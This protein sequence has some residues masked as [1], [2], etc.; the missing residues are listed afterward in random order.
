MMCLFQVRGLTWLIRQLNGFP[1]KQGAGDVGAVRETISRLNEGYI[2]NVFPEGT[3]TLDGEI[4]QIQGGFSLIIRKVDV[5]VIPVAIH[6]S[7]R[8]WKPGTK[9]FKPGKI[10][11]RYGPPLH[12]KGLKPAQIVELTDRVLHQML[13]QLRAED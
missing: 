8:A 1:I 7:Y 4:S 12:V 2:L 6:G 9:F 3:R 11:V 5:P 13:D 10:R